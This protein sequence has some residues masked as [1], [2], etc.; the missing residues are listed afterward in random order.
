MAQPSFIERLEQ[1]RQSGREGAAVPGPSEPPVS[2]NTRSRRAT[3]T[4]PMTVA[5]GMAQLLTL[6][7][8]QHQLAAITLSPTPTKKELLAIL[9]NR[10]AEVLSAVNET[11]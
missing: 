11:G 3:L 1:R 5:Q 9:E 8:S 4:V 6:L 10:T 2:N 7:A